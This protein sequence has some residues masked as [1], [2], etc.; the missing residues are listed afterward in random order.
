MNKYLVKITIEQTVEAPDEDIARENAI[1]NFDFSDLS[2]ADWDI[3]ELERKLKVF[4]GA[5]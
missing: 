1:W 5:N 2:Y 3:K 4:R